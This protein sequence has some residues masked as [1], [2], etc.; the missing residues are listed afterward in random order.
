MPLVKKLFAT[1]PLFTWTIQGKRQRL[2]SDPEVISLLRAAHIS[3]AMGET[4]ENFMKSV[5]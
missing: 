4:F 1:L 3:G 5:K 2:L